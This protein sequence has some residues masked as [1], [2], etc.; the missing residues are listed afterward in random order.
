MTG[1]GAELVKGTQSFFLCCPGWLANDAGVGVG[2]INT[3]DADLLSRHWCTLNRFGPHV[4]MFHVTLTRR[5]WGVTSGA[6]GTSMVRGRT[7]KGE[8]GARKEDCSHSEHRMWLSRAGGS[9]CM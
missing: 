7:R 1:C 3:V 2:D 5:A 4:H 8:R 6:A 9:M